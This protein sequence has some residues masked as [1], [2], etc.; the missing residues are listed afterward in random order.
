[1]FKL[2][3]VTCHMLRFA[4][5]MSLTPTAIAMGPPHA[6][7]PNLYSRVVQ[8]DTKIN[9]QCHN[10][11]LK[12]LLVI[13]LFIIFII[14]YLAH[15]LPSLCGCRNTKIN[16]IAPEAQLQLKQRYEKELTPRDILELSW[17]DFC[18]LAWCT[19]NLC[20][21]FFFFK[22]QIH[23]TTQPWIH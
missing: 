19:V 12:N 16:D 6:N 10:L 15:H 23:C 8:E 17:H 7:S 20:D 5:H 2:S 18:C 9:D 21:M 11:S 3:S 13:Y 4:F 1:M 14:I 22:I